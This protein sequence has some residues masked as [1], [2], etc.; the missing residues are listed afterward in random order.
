MG[1]GGLVRLPVHRVRQD[2][3]DTL[4]AHVAGEGGRGAAFPCAPA[5]VQPKA[6]AFGCGAGREAPPFLALPLPFSQRLTPLLAVLQ[7]N[8]V[9]EGIENLGCRTFST[10]ET[11]YCLIGLLH[12]AIVQMAAEAP[13]W[14]DQ[15]GGWQ[16][17]TDLKAASAS[18][19][20][21]V[22]DESVRGREGHTAAFPP[23]LP[24]PFC[25]RLMHLLAVLG[26]RRCLSSR[27]RYATG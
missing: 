21:A 8:I 18:L 22:Y 27:C 19:R 1:L 9:A 5:A 16:T 15:T 25:Q 2:R 17:I 3:V 7:N 12:P 23:A 11:A 6:D 20:A 24:L 14:L 10:L 13:I 4:G 26:E